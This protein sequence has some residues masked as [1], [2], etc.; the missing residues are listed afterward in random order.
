MP[1][2]RA[3]PTR[4]YPHMPSN[5]PAPRRNNKGPIPIRDD[6]TG[7][8]YNVKPSV[9]SVRKFDAVGRPKPKARKDY[10][11]IGEPVPLVRPQ[12]EELAR[13][14]TESAEVYDQERAERSLLDRLTTERQKLE[15]RI[16]SPPPP[17]ISRIAPGPSNYQIPAPP[18]PDLHFARTKFLR[19]AHEFH[20]IIMAVRDQFDPI[21]EQLVEY[22]KDKLGIV[23]DIPQELREGLWI[24]WDRL[25]DIGNEIDTISRGFKEQDWR[26]FGGALKRLKKVDTKLPLVDLCNVLSEMNIT[27]P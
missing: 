3:K 16:T 12:G 4:S 13:R 2:I 11:R 19:R 7:I 23:V 27:L 15:E 20:A 8:R 26:N 1:A 17:L 24:W 25:E 14:L 9:E 22:E 10:W 21:F 5:T 18:P 6:I